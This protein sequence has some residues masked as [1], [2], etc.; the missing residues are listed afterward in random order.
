M[1][2]REVQKKTHRASSDYEYPEEEPHMS[3]SHLETLVG[4]PETAVTSP[5]TLMCTLTRYAQQNRVF[6]AGLVAR[7]VFADLHK[8]RIHL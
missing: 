4:H 8:D 2:A 3:E 7:C 1:T 5:K 6:L